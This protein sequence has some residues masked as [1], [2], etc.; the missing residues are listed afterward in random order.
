MRFP[1]PSPIFIVSTAFLVLLI[2]LWEQVVKSGAISDTIVAA[3]TDIGDA[4]WRGLVLGAMWFDVW[5]T[6]QEI[7]Y[8]FLLGSLVGIVLGSLLGESK[9]L[10]RLLRP[11][12]VGFQA[13]PKIALAPIIVIWFGYDIASKVAIATTIAF[14]PVLIN[15]ITGIRSTPESHID[16]MKAYNGSRFDVFM[17]V[18]VPNALPYVF[19]G[20]QVAV[21]LAVVG[22]IVGEFLGAERGLGYVVLSAGLQLNMATVFAAIIVI[23]VLATVLTA[24]IAALEK[25]VVFWRA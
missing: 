1:R 5:V 23:A 12:V 7:V 18:K 25:R 22:A 20:L 24:L 2:F 19:A 3:P 15:T 4:L 11:Y 9:F 14:F 10:D 13:I 6:L 8:G 16:L 21:T 17:W